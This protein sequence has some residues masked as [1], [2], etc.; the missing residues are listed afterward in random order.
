[1]VDG[2]KVD[3]DRSEKGTHRHQGKALRAQ[4]VRNDKNVSH[5]PGER[6]KRSRPEDK[7][8]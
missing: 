1:L 3:N 4:G 7:G 2:D 5:L 6:K 8:S